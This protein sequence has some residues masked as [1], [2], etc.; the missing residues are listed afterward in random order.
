MCAQ[1]P[2]TVCIVQV[3]ANIIGDEYPNGVDVLINDAGINSPFQRACEQYATLSKAV[4]G[5]LC[6]V[7]SPQ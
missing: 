1:M 5:H 6:A 4:L 2:S 3:A 7:A